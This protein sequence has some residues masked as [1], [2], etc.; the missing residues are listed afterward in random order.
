[1]GMRNP[2]SSAADRSKEKYQKEKGARIT[3]G[4]C[5]SVSASADRRSEN[6]RIFAVIIAELELRNIQRKILFAD[7]MEGADHAALEDRPEAFNRIG[8]NRANNVI[9]ARMVNSD[10]LRK[11][12]IQ[13]LIADP[14]IRNQ[15]A[16]LMRDGFIHEAFKRD[17][18]D[19]LNNAGNDIA[20]A[21]N[22]TNNNGF[23]GTNAASSTTAPTVMPVFGFAADKS[24]VNLDNAAKFF[25]FLIGQRGANAMAIYQAV[26]SE[27]KPM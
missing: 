21:A 9:A 13:V 10:V 12:F 22:G 2:E 15:Q 24:F 17:G 27:P 26:L 4:L 7:V 20:L 3:R 8:V 23:T 19:V 11:F 25:E 14:L 1:M 16:N 6:V 5:A 18:A